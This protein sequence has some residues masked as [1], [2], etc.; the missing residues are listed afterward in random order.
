MVRTS[1]QEFCVKCFLLRKLKVFP[2]T[3]QWIVSE[4]T[5]TNHGQFTKLE[6]YLKWVCPELIKD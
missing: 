6:T 3:V 5:P 4:N 1:F 2:D